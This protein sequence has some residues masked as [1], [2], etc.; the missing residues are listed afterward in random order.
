MYSQIRNDAWKTTGAH[1]HLQMIIH[2]MYNSTISHTEIEESLRNERSALSGCTFIFFSNKD[3][4]C[5][6]TN[7]SNNR[8]KSLWEIIGMNFQGSKLRPA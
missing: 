5:A 1:I 2:R 7:Y 8:E 6:E 3:F 4:Q